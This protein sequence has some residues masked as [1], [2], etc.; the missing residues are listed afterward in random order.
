VLL[1]EAIQ[2]WEEPADYQIRILAI[3]EVKRKHDLYRRAFDAEN[4][5][6]GQDRALGYVSA[7]LIRFNFVK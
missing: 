3:K 7:E 4:Y 5:H 6:L 1:D 2:E